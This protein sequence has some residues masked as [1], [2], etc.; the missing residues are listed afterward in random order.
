MFPLS[1][2][3]PNKFPKHDSVGKEWSTRCLCVEHPDREEGTIRS[4]TLLLSARHSLFNKHIVFLPQ[5]PAVYLSKQFFVPLCAGVVPLSSVS[6]GTRLTG[7][8]LSKC[9]C[10]WGH[11]LMS[12]AHFEATAVA[13]FDV[14]RYHDDNSFCSCLCE[15]K[16]MKD[17]YWDFGH[18]HH[19]QLCGCVAQLIFVSIKHYRINKIKLHYGNM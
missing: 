7:F 18:H 12:S 13:V 4:R 2:L 8:S 3:Q 14:Y 16:R 1:L 11:F 19:W 5:L 17:V 6:F 9:K 10:I 15:D